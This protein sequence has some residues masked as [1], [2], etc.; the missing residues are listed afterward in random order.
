MIVSGTPS[1]VLIVDD[2]T[3]MR[4][5]LRTSLRAGGYKVT[6]KDNGKAA[7][8][9]LR[10]RPISSCLILICPRSMALRSSD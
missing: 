10:R 9:E 8:A 7:L 6:K 1:R 4:R 2:D 3:T 5:F